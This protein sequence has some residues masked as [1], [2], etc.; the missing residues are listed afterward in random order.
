MFQRFLLGCTVL[1]LCLW[2]LHVGFVGWVV[3]FY[4]AFV[5]FVFITVI[6][7]VYVY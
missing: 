3:G 1:D 5:G 6:I 2:V 7:Y 4:F